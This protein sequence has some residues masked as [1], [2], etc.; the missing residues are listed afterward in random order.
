[1]TDAAVHL[2]QPSTMMAAGLDDVAVF[3][4]EP[5]EHFGGT[6]TRPFVE[7]FRAGIAQLERKLTENGS[8]LQKILRAEIRVT[9]A[10]PATYQ[11]LQDSFLEG[12]AST[13]RPARCVSAVPSLPRGA[14]VAIGGVAIVGSGRAD[15]PL[16]AIVA[17]D[18]PA[19]C[20]PF[21]HARV[22][23]SGVWVTAQVGSDPA[24]GS[25]APVQGGTAVQARYAIDN[26]SAILKASG[27]TLFDVVHARVQYVDE[28]EWRVL[29]DLAASET[30]PPDVVEL[31]HVPFIPTAQNGVTVKVD[32]VARRPVH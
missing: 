16:S 19:P 15:S 10:G 2:V 31:V 7:Q 27:A 9:Q 12:F 28:D 18:G 14:Q 8:S 20:A 26:L 23:R 3:D 6:D 4:A 22:Y 30:W 32:A 13:P 24:T 29:A 21:P 25:L 5:D 11:A 1:M 17:S